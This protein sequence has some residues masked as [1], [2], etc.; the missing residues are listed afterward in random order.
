[1]KRFQ[2]GLVLSR[3]VYNYVDLL[4]PLGDVI[5]LSPGNQDYKKTDL[6]VVPHLIGLDPYSTNISGSNGRDAQ[7]FP[8]NFIG[9]H[10]ANI[11]ANDYTIL[12]LGDGAVNLYSRLNLQ[13][14]VMEE[15]IGYRADYTNIEYVRK[16]KAII[17]FSYKKV[18]GLNEFSYDR[19]LTILKENT[20][21]SQTVGE[22]YS[23]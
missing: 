7:F 5:I 20:D 3:E 23:Q 15:Y 19:V 17:G 13:V 14:E 12:G 21:D 4:T 8:H 16:N 9:R 2:I 6:I 1:M 10:I 22:L 11:M 18:Y